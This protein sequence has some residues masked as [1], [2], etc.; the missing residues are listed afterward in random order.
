MSSDTQKLIRE[1]YRDASL[2]DQEKARKV[3]VL[4][5]PGVVASESKVEESSAPKPCSH[6]NIRCDVF[7]D[8][9]G[10][11]FPCRLCHD[12]EEDHKIDRYSIK[13]IRCRECSHEQPKSNMCEY[14]GI[15]FANTY[16]DKCNLW[17][18]SEEVF[19]CDECNIRHNG[20]QQDHF[21]CK[22][23]NLDILKIYKDTHTCRNF[24]TE[25]CCGVC[26]EDTQKSRQHV[27]IIPTCKHCVHYDCYKQLIDN[28][29][30]QCPTC[31]ASLASD[32]SKLWEHIE[33]LVQEQPMPE[34]YRKKVIVYCN[35][36]R[37]Q[38]ETDY[39]FIG[40][41]CVVCDGYNTTLVWV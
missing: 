33:G 11:W 38:C 30:F 8:C 37:V 10:K 7:A 28:N 5:N 22:T 12:E 39:H 24:T 16:C 26:H 25:T 23:C 34:Q 1:I 40:N 13:T 19:H 31:K 3:F 17:T 35:D 29:H 15:Q 9:C 41:K 14:C 4:M 32:M 27:I 18:H 6:Y 20:K 21:H 2:S 36:C